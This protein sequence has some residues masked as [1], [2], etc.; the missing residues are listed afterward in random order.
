ME[1]AVAALEAFR[2]DEGRDL[3]IW[4]REQCNRSGFSAV[5]ER[6]AKLLEIH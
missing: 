2:Y 3:V 6:L 5:K 1:S 4:L